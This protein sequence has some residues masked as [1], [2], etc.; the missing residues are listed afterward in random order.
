[1]AA[2]YN[3]KQMNRTYFFQCMVMNVNI[4]RFEIFVYNLIPGASFL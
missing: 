4:L 2:D 3:A 1:M